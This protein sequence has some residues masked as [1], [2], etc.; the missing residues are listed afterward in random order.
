MD[1]SLIKT[2]NLSFSY[3]E[4]E[5]DICVLK[6]ISLEIARGE[7]VALLG[8]NG[9]GKS[10]LAKHFNA[11]LLPC[12]GKIYVCGM[13]TANEDLKFKIRQQ[14]GMVLQNPDNQLVATIVEEDVAFGPENL[15]FEQSEIRKRVDNALKAVGM[16]EYKDHAPH[17][18]SGGQKQRVAI[19]GIIAMEPDCI[20]FDEPTAML[21]PVGRREVMETIERLCHEKNIAVVLITH[22]M[23]E[24]A[25]ADRI[26]VMDK[27]NI[28]LSG[29]PAK[30]FSDVDFMRSH[31]LDVPQ[32]TA[33]AQELK[34]RGIYLGGNILNPQQCADSIYKLWRCYGGSSEN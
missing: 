13:D 33:L 2:H 9:S 1:N 8:H 3:T 27:G 22:N 21:D 32:S 26:I 19:A 34:K 20:V 23:D 25:R 5:Q 31:N 28:L 14:V 17:K 18:L 6:D 4:E 15:G 30:V 24:A 10:T 16:Y 29:T 7:F 12:G 11:M